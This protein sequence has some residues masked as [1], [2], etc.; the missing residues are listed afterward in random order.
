MADDYTSSLKNLINKPLCYV[1]HVPITE[2]F[3]FY[4]YNTMLCFLPIVSELSKS[5]MDV[6]QSQTVFSKIKNSFSPYFQRPVPPSTDSYTVPLLQY[7]ALTTCTITIHKPLLCS[8]HLHI[9]PTLLHTL[10]DAANGVCYPVNF[11]A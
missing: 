10:L 7:G 11:S 2:H 5:N 8:S 6:S 1:M 4:D 3:A 9:S